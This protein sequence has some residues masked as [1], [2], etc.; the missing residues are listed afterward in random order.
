[1][2]KNKGNS[3]Y[4]NDSIS[5]ISDDQITTHKVLDIVGNSIEYDEGI[6]DISDAKK[7]YDL[8]NSGMHYYFNLDIPSKVEAMNLKMLRR[9]QALNNIF[10]YDR[11][12]KFDL[13]GFMPWLIIV[14]LVLFK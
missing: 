3:N 10:K 1:M 7:Y 2:A 8:N 13:V 9:S 11:G 12:K 5:I 6:L 14:L 4:K